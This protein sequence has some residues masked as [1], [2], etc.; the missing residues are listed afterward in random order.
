MI[1]IVDPNSWIT[2]LLLEERERE[3]GRK[4]GGEGVLDRV[5]VGAARGVVKVGD[6][7]LACSLLAH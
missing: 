2:A 5:G 6:L 4:R 3:L 1:Y 7:P